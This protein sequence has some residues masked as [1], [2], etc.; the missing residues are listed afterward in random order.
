ME[1]LSRLTRFHHSSIASGI[2]IFASTRW[3]SS[4]K[5]GPKISIPRS[6]VILSYARSSGPGGQNVNKVNTKAELRF[7][8]SEAD[9]I[10]EETR[11]RFM[12]QNANRINSAGEFLMT[13]DRTRMQGTNTQDCFDKTEHLL[14]IASIPPVERI[15]T[16][17]PE[18]AKEERMRE[19]KKRSGQKGD[20][21]NWKNDM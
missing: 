6:R 8:V 15:E 7:K 11:L 4:S 3:G 21:R 10:P 2:N 18:Y 5:D 20:R 13:S 19:K 17:A 16:E 1:F 14:E 9:W 12:Q